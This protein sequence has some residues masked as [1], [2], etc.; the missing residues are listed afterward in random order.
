MNTDKDAANPVV[1]LIHALRLAFADAKVKILM[2]LSFWQIGLAT[3]F[4][5]FIEKWSWVDAFYFSVIT[6]ATVGYGDFSPQTVLGKLFTVGYILVGIGLFVTATAT[7][8]SQMLFIMQRQKS[9]RHDTT[10]PTK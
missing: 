8:A 1:E 4:Y 10:P 3:V 6:V 7:L 9:E 2:T 5:H